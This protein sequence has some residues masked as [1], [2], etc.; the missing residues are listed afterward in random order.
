M[1]FHFNTGG[2]EK[3][4]KQVY[5]RDCATR[6]LAIANNLDYKVAYKLMWKYQNGTPRNGVSTKST[7]RCL[8]DIGWD[9][10]DI[11]S[12]HIKINEF[13]FPNGII[14]C[15]IKGH[16]TT[17][18]NGIINDTWNCSKKNPEIVGY[19]IKKM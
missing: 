18:I 15:R 11:K 13:K 6:A 3:Y 16:V 5:V 19:W 12:E 4:Y 9:Y 2:R 7:N 1:E 17:I 8:S 14:I 10:H